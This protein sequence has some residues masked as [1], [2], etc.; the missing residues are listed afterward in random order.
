MFT[1]ILHASQQPPHF[2]LELEN[3][4][5]SGNEYIHS[6]T[7]PMFSTVPFLADK[8]T[9]CGS[10]YSAKH[11]EWKLGPNK[12]FT[13]MHL[14]LISLVSR[15]WGRLKQATKAAAVQIQQDVLHH[16][17]SVSVVQ[18]GAQKGFMLFEG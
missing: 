2:G 15:G 1:S 7:L 17:V 13:L 16:D 8:K 4:S 11:K 18:K 12:L 9:S 10:T 14:Y 6:G 3:Q 5:F